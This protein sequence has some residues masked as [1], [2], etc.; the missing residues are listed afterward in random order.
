MQTSAHAAGARRHK[1]ACASGAVVIGTQDGSQRKLVIAAIVI[2]PFLISTYFSKRFEHQLGDA[3]HHHRRHPAV[4]AEQQ[5]GGYLQYG[6]E[7]TMG[8]EDSYKLAPL[9]YIID[10]ERNQAP[11]A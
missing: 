11:P 8:N 2:V 4:Y 7:I 1:R 3:E 10:T 5:C 9:P 6:L